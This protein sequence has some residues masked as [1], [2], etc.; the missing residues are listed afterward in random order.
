LIK[1]KYKNKIKKLILSL[2][3]CTL[4]IILSSSCS[5]SSSEETQTPPPAAVVF[6]AAYNGVY[7]GTGVETGSPVTG[8]VTLTS[9][10][11]TT[12]SYVVILAMFY[13]LKLRTLAVQIL[14]LKIN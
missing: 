8:S 5:K 2:F 10:S 12:G 9:S 11:V 6:S 1:L 14:L 3:V 7:T 13:F 4:S